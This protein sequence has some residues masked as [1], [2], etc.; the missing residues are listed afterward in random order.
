MD[1]QKIILLSS[2][3]RCEIWGALLHTKIPL[4]LLIP[5]SF[6]NMAD[7]PSTHS[8]KRYRHIGLPCCNPLVDVILPF[9]SSLMRTEN[10]YILTHIMEREIHLS[11]KPSFLIILK[12]RPLHYHTPC[13]Y[14][15]LLPSNPLFLSFFEFCGAWSQK[16]LACCL[17]SAFQAQMQFSLH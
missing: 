10:D 14:W 4:I 13:S 16:Q 5:I 12:V 15:V 9:S 11:W 2:N 17:W 7:K 6:R 1:L 8:K 3:R